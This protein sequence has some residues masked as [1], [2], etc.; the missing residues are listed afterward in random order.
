MPLVMFSYCVQHVSKIARVLSMEGGNA[1]LVGVGGSGRQSL[2]RLAA[3]I[4]ECDVFQIEISK[5]YAY[6]DWRDDIKK[7]LMNAGAQGKPTVFLFTDSQIQEETYVEDINNLLNAGEVPN[8]WA[9][10]EKAIIMEAVATQAKQNGRKLG[11]SMAEH[12]TYFVELCRKN[13]HVVL[14]FSPIGDAFRTRLRMFPSLINCCTI[15]WFQDWPEEGLTAVARRALADL[16]LDDEVKQNCVSMCKHFHSSVKKVSDKFQ[17]SLRRTVYITPTSYLELISA[18]KTLLNVKKDE[19]AIKKSRYENGLVAIKTTEASVDGMKEELIALQP[20]LVIAQQETAEM[21]VVIERETEEANKVKVVVEAEEAEANKTAQEVKAVKD[22]CEADLAEAI[23]VL[24]SAV[25]ALD[26]LKKSDIDE[27]KN[28]GKPPAGVRLTMAAV[29]T[30]KGIKPKM[31]DDPEKM[32]KKMPDFW[33]PAKVL[34]GD[35]KFLQ[36]LKDF[37]KDNIP[38]KVIQTIRDKYVADETFVPEIIKKASLAAEGLCKWVRAIESYDRVAKVVAPKK[39]QLAKAEAEFAEVMAKLSIKQAQLKEVM[40]KLAGLTSTFNGLKQKQADLEAQVDMCE[41]KLD[42]AEKLI[43]SLGGEKSR[44]TDSAAQLGIKLTNVTGDVLVAAGMVAYV[45]PFTKLFREEITS[46]WIRTAGELNVPRSEVFSLIATLGEPVQIREWNIQ[47]LPSDD[48]SIEN[49]IIV[50]IGRRW[51][52]MIDPQEQGN[53]WIRNMEIENKLTRVKLSGEYLRTLENSIQFG[54]PVLLEDIGESL[55]PSLEPLL[56]KQIFTQGGMQCIRLGDATIEYSPDFRFYISTKLRNPH[57]APETAVKVSLVNFMITPEGLEDQILGTVVAME[58]PDLQAQKEEL[59]L[60]GA[61]NA[62]KLKEIEDKIL[63]IL[64]GEGNILDDEA[65]IQVLSSSKVVANEIEAK[66]AAGAETEKTIDTA[67][68]SYRPI[69]F[70][71]SILFFNIS[72]LCIIDP[73]YQY[74]LVWF[75]TLFEQSITK[76]KPNSDVPTR[77]QILEEHFTYT[78]YANVCRSLFEKDK[79]L[80]SFTMCVAI[81]DGANLMDMEEYSFLLT[82]GVSLAANTQ[83]N[84][85]KG[86]LADDRWDQICRLGD[87]KAFEGINTGFATQLSEWKAI[88][89]SDM[90]HQENLPGQWQSKLSVFQKILVLRAIRPDK[91]VPAIQ[92]YVATEMGVKFVE[93]PPFD[94]KQCYDDSIATAPLIFVLSPGSDPMSALLKFAEEKKMGG[95]KFQTISLGQGQGPRAMQLLKAAREQGTWVVLQNCHL[96]KSFMPSFETLV[97]GMTNEN[98]HSEFRM[99]CTSYPSPIFPVALLQ[100]GVKMTQEPPKGVK[101]NMMRSYLSDPVSDEAF[102]ADISQ[103]KVLEWHKM[104]FGMCFFHSLVQERR[105]FGPLGWNIPY[106]FNESDQRISIQQLQMF[107]NEYEETPF[108]A[109]LYT[110]G[111]CNYGGRVTDD[112]DRRVLLSYLSLFYT[113]DIM[114]E[115]Y[116]FSG[117]EAAKMYFAPPLGPIDTI[118]EYL[119]GLPLEQPPEIFGLHSNANLTKDQNETTLLFTSIISTRSGGGGG[120]GSGGKSF[121]EMVEEVADEILAKL[122]PDFDLE[123]AGNK[124]PTDPME[125]MN[126]VLNQEL[127]RYIKLTSTIRKSLLQLKQAIKGFVVM[128][129]ELDAVAQSL[130]VGFVPGMWM[131]VSYPNLKPLGAYVTDLIERLDFFQGWMDKGTPSIFW[132]SGFFFQPSFLTGALQNFA[133]KYVYPIDS[134]TVEYEFQSCSVSERD[135]KKPD[136]GV[137]VYGLFMEGARFNR[138]KMLMDESFPKTLFD[139]MPV[140]LIRPC[141]KANLTVFPNYECPLYKTLDRRGVLATSGHSTNFVMECNVPTDR[142]ESHWINRGVAMCVATFCMLRLRCS[143]SEILFVPVAGSAPLRLSDLCVCVID[144]LSGNPH[145]SHRLL[146][147]GTPAR[148]KCPCGAW[149]LKCTVVQSVG[150]FINYLHVYYCSSPLACHRM[151]SSFFASVARHPGALR[152]RLLGQKNQPLVPVNKLLL[153]LSPYLPAL[154][155][156]RT[157]SRATP[158]SRCPRHLYFPPAAKYYIFDASSVA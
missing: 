18:F 51:P 157:R 118:I 105:A 32:G 93:S 143:S 151:S 46:D 36:S 95:D 47:G 14:A 21:M 26:T 27:V 100:N 13:L 22:D 119:Q 69:A 25:A 89:D 31:V 42:R 19:V 126:T 129:A 12:M 55:D 88:Y 57:Y 141:Q 103:A 149:S 72:D 153:P 40:D 154:A 104:L 1:L 109:L 84:P 112:H 96:A 155:A 130:S 68:E 33:I 136:D 29:C 87:L 4:Q 128:S 41:K 3:H 111:Q 71:A 15:D 133:R 137:Y 34:L 142:P 150:D 121:D 63:E 124:Y 107:L 92:T 8:L 120:G 64:S 91:C 80:F 6:T 24:K 17:A 2:T 125:S 108:T 85:G 131:K 35:P 139:E 138:E 127:I 50:D 147:A 20:K 39:A 67:R 59:V 45:G 74:S 156:G 79:L 102:Y 9:N 23:P 82:G 75:V 158:L 99:W 135:W 117:E 116:T 94:L 70:H 106:G 60:E 56:L 11:G 73:M 146:S 65:G 86:W 61:A 37:D 110:A 145:T 28:M 140:G 44:W 62:R 66:Q 78:L 101:A 7:F 114:E 48:F 30:M 83:R 38:D 132:F 53:K 5:N 54:T 152:Q 58:R 97:E 122:P 123:V 52:L 98:C 81:R 115:G 16:T 113:Q 144:L 148:S 134:C 43:I 49:G 76:S 77:L 10:D 90:P